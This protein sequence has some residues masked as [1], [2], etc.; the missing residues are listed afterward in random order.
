MS[1]THTVSISAIKCDFSS[2]VHHMVKDKVLNSCEHCLSV[3]QVSSSVCT[4]NFM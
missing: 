2:V 4:I 3:I 1:S